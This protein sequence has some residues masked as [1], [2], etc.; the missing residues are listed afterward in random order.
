R[1]SRPKRIGSRWHGRYRGWHRSKAACAAARWMKRA[2]RSFSFERRLV[3]LASGIEPPLGPRLGRR[4]AAEFDTVVQAE[5]AVVPELETL[6]VNAPAAPA[7]RARH[8][9]DDV[10]G[11]DQR[12]RLLEGKAAFQRLRLLA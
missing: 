11:G 2:F 1:A 7:G 3:R 5:R 12:D 6:G 9:A 4:V 8:F 10:P